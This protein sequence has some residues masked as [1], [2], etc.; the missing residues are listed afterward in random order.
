MG[1]QAAAEDVVVTFT[2]EEAELLRS[3]AEERGLAAEELVR[4]SVGPLLPRDEWG[5]QGFEGTLAEERQ[6]LS[7]ALD[8]LADL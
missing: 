4:G 7:G 6:R 1:G 8:R 5:E 3:A 2:G